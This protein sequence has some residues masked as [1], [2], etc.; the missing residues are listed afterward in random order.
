VKIRS[1]QKF[2]N[3]RFKELKLFLSSETSSLLSASLQARQSVF[4]I[5]LSFIYF[6]VLQR[7]A[8]LARVCVSSFSVINRL[9][10]SLLCIQSRNSYNTSTYRQLQQT[11]SAHLK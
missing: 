7:Q 6:N 5:T 8:T 9:N 4:L 1:F 2:K 3:K 10:L 11:H